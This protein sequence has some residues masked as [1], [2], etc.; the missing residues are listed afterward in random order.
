M[1][2]LRIVGTYK[3]MLGGSHDH[4]VNQWVSTTMAGGA[5]LV[6]QL[7]QEARVLSEANHKFTYTLERKHVESGTWNIINRYVNGA[8][9]D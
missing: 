8:D 5:L 3:D 7:R 1:Y 6:K 2:I 4:I 9:I